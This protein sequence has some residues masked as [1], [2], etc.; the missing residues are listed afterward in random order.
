MTEDEKLAIRRCNEI[1]LQIATG[2]RINLKLENNFESENQDLKELFN[3][4]QQ[5]SNQYNNSY[6]F[7]IDLSNGKLDTIPPP[8]NSFANPFKQLHSELMYLTWQI[9]EISKGDYEQ[10]VSFSGDFSEAI[11]KMVV[12]LKD[13]DKAE[14]ALRESEAKLKETLATKDKFFSI[15]A[16]DLKNPFNGLIGLS[17]VL[18]EKLIPTENE[19]IIK[20][21]KLI[22]ESS[23]R[24]FQLLVNLLEWSRL[25]T[26]SIKIEIRPISLDNIVNETV[27]IM[28]PDILDKKITITTTGIIGLEVFSDKNIL[29]TV[30]RNLISN[31]IKYSNI[32]GIIQIQ[33]MKKDAQVIISVEDNGMG[34]KEEDLKKLF[35]MDINFTIKGTK[36]ET[37]TGLGL[38]LCKDFIH[39]LGGDIRVESEFGK[40]SKFIFSLPNI[41]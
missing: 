36:N 7:I 34:I 14:N 9:Q 38:I 27:E 40:G 33:A 35:R 19:K 2:Q 5:L 17:Q 21:A 41:Y 24:G 39:K 8:K 12:S 1:V 18:V 13:K 32:S 10:H 30:L 29:T 23:T 15:I 28:R 22:H 25:Q 20:I 26:D 37:G 4:I 11:N 16:H 3:S 6:N 31:A